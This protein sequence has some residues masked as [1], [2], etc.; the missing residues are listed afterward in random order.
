MKGKRPL[1]Y[2]DIE[3][4]RMEIREINKEIKWLW[5]IEGNAF[6]FDYKQMQN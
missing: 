4:R 3:T 2:I 6:Q 1:V 5:K